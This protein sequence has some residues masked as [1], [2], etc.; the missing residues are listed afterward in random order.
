MESM[1]A[2][3]CVSTT[4]INSSQLKG[5]RLD[6]NSFMTLLF[7]ST[8]GCHLCEEAET[9]LDVLKTQR[10]VTVEAI[11][12]STSA[13]LVERYGIRIPVVKNQATGEELDW[14]FGY[15]ELLSLI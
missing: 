3:S 12:I 7:Y 2:S 6:E 10:N 9:L 11:D 4:T 1:G 13:A 8:L 15:D 5:F 14:P